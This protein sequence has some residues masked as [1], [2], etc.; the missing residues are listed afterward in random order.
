[1]IDITLPEGVIRGIEND[2]YR[3]WHGVPYAK[4]P[5][6]EHR[7]KAP[8]PPE[9]WV[10]VRMATEPAAKPWQPAS[11]GGMPSSSSVMS[12]DCLHLNICTPTGTPP[13]DGWPVLFFIHGGGDVT[14]SEDDLGQGEIFARQGIAVVKPDYRL[15]AFGFLNLATA[16]NLPDEIDAGACGLLDQ[17]AALQWTHDRIAAFGGNP[18]QI[19]IYGESAGAKA[20]GNLLG[21]PMTKGL[22][23]QAISSSG[24]ADDVGQPEATAQVAHVFLKQLRVSNI[25]QLRKMPAQEILN[26]QNALG[27]GVKGTWIWRAT[28]HPKAA[29]LVPIE[30]IRA[31]CAAGVRLLVGN[32][33]NEAALFAYQSSLDTCIAPARDVLGNILGEERLAQLL[34]TYQKE[35]NID[36]DH[37]LLA[38]MGD[39]RYAI[40]TLRE[41]DAQTAH[42]TVYRYRLDAVPAGLPNE[43]KGA[44]GTDLFMV[45]QLPQMLKALPA[46]APRQRLATAVHD[47]WVS[48]I[49]TGT[50]TAEDLPKW[51][52]YDIE[53]RQTMI[54]NDTSTI[55]SDPR[56]DE[57][58]I[59][60]DTTWQYGTWFPLPIQ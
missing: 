37:A 55:E 29:P 17:I 41:A 50:P 16:L 54:F 13:K 38:G 43:L 33:C 31:G 35:R 27:I 22:Y 49:K 23:S 18:N 47:A 12:E 59:W 52:K 25:D 44:H 46:T 11:S 19:T 53:K 51:P 36:A 34:A 6:E 8:Q 1:M 5:I 4:P 21:S 39:E 30:N 57:R 15:G 2:G 40:S 58:V 10:G 14:G 28:L 56:K 3:L 7:W 60:G 20:I 32:N 9:K 45:W 42:G 24:G 26:A 48:F